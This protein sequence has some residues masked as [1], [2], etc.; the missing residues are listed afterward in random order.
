M[1]MP[2]CNDGFTLAEIIVTRVSGMTFE[3]FLEQEIFTPFGMDLSGFGVGRETRDLSFARFYQPSGSVEPLEVIS[4]LATGGISSTSNDLTL[5]AHKIL[6]D[7]DV[8]SENAKNELLASQ[9]SGYHDALGNDPITFGLGWDYPN[10]P[11]FEDDSLR[12]YGKSGGTGHYTSMLFTIPSEDISV[13]LLLTGSSG[14]ATSIALD[15]LE[16]YL[17]DINLVSKAMPSSMIPIEAEPMP[18]DMLDYEGYY[19]L[20]VDTLLISFDID[21][22]YM[23]ISRVYGNSV[24]PIANM[25]HADGKFYLG[26]QIFFFTTILDSK[27][28]MTY[29]FPYRGQWVPIPAGELVL[30]LD[31]AFA[32]DIDTEDSLW[33]RTN[34][35]PYEH[36][37]MI[38][39][40]LIQMRTIDDLPGYVD[41]M[42]LMRVTST[43]TTEMAATA[44]RDLYVLKLIDVNGVNWIWLSGGLYMPLESALTLNLEDI[45]ITIDEDGLNVW[46]YVSQDMTI[47]A[48]VPEDARM[49]VFSEEGI[50]Y[51]NLINEGLI[52]VPEGSLIQIIGQ[53][54]AKVSITPTS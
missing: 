8:L 44:I 9:S 39:S 10:M 19:T 50:I 28:L 41:F 54:G 15:I 12:V 42:G 18:E 38:E 5:F 14:N 20:G 29:L 11:V 7:Q 31:D 23:T 16:A 40:N 35:S 33:L 49:V 24:S 6:H 4:M 53:A 37:M 36:T 13:A 17:I 25:I 51:D 48:V 32:L 30:P 21:L 47:D 1:Y 46:F 2:Y 3:A 27:L 34:A 22:G 43:T 45:E 26:N 52:F